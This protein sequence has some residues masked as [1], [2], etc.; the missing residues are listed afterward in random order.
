LKAHLDFGVTKGAESQKLT[1]KKQDLQL[2][3]K[4]ANTGKVFTDMIISSKTEE[5]FIEKCKSLY[6]KCK[7][8]IETNNNTEERT[9]G[10]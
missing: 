5:E 9:D 10:N 6:R 2:I 4:L 7:S 8:T 3:A 1:N